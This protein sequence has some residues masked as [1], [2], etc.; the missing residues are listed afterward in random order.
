MRQFV[1]GD[2]GE[3]EEF[4]DMGTKPSPSLF[5]SSNSSS[6]YVYR[7]LN[8]GS[9]E[10]YGVSSTVGR[11]MPKFSKFSKVTKIPASIIAQHKNN[12]KTAGK[13][14]Q[15]VLASLMKNSSSSQGL[16]SQASNVLN[17]AGQFAINASNMAL[18]AIK[19]SIDKV[20][21]YHL[22]S[23]VIK[24]APKP[25]VLTNT[26]PSVTINSNAKPVSST[27]AVKTVSNDQLKIQEPKSNTGLIAGGAVAVGL[28]ALLMSR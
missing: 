6:S 15:E 2:F 19:P 26:S 12:Q 23:N 7:V 27:P 5:S 16:F 21:N 20:A 10:I 24:P 9:G 25:A 22:S 4:D 11:S 28:V 13:V 8:D 14:P 3:I 17:S 18:D 1:M